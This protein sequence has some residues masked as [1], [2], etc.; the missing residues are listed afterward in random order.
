MEP[1]LI[2]IPEKLMTERLVLRCPRS[3]DGKIANVAICA[4][5]NDLHRWMDWAESKPTVEQSEA[6][7][8]EFQVRFI[9]REEMVYLLFLKG[10]E[11]F[12]GVVSLTPKDW[13][14][15]KFEIGYWCHRDHQN[16][17]YTTEAVRC[18]T[19]LAFEK[20]DAIRIEIRC[21]AEN[22]R[23]Y[24]VAEKLGYQLEGKLKQETLSTNPAKKYRD[25]LIFA[26]IKPDDTHT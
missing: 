23:S 26:K 9:A 7:M 6:T 25:T 17:G 8:R 13:R 12:V 24:R 5:F 3:G 19:D 16:R 18:L 11:T 15:P 14:L 2:E 21:D 10:T 1:I 20:L 22:V 4:T